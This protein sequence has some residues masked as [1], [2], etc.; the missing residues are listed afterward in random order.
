MDII[1]VHFINLIACIVGSGF[2]FCG[3]PGGKYVCVRL[4]VIMSILCFSL[5]L[6]LLFALSWSN[7]FGF[8][9]C[10]FISLSFILLFFNR[11][12]FVF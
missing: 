12:L 5:A 9:L 4:C 8:V 2:V 6:F 3:L 11:G 7:L 10:Y 1:L